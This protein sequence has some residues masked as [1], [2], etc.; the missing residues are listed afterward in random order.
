M[1]LN[2]HDQQK[3]T[4]CDGT[5]LQKMVVTTPI[6]ILHYKVRNQFYQVIEKNN[7]RQLSDI[8]LK[9]IG[10]NGCFENSLKPIQPTN[11]K[12][13]PNALPILAVMIYVE[14]NKFC[15]ITRVYI[16]KSH[17]SNLVLSTHRKTQLS[18]I[19]VYHFQNNPHN[20]L[21]IS[22]PINPYTT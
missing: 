10:T 11:S 8:I 18:A 2:I 12:I 7:Y 4:V 13:P 22:K 17:T 14:K 19:I 15:V 9:I 16:L 6:L 20:R 21:F 1:A 3:T 5:R